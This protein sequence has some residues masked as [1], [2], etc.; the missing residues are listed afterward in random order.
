MM[1][2]LLDTNILVEILRGN[3]KRVASAVAQVGVDNCL[4]SDM[5]YFELLVGAECS[6]YIAENL[7]SVQTLTEKIHIVPSFPSFP[8]AASEKARLRR[9]GALIP[10]L[11]ILIACTAANNGCI[12][13]TN[14][15]RHMSRIRGLTIQDWA[16]D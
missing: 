9:E 10:D 13:V 5:S 12:L 16:R 4:M 8:M 3:N 6:A 2:Y 7:A 11:D 14:D 1:Q 15:A